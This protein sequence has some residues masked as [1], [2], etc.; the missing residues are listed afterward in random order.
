MWLFFPYHII[1]SKELV[2]INIEIRKPNKLKDFSHKVY[3]KLEDILFSIIQRLPERFIPPLLMAWLERYTDRRIAELNQQI[4][5]QR[6]HSAELQK[7]VN[8][9]HDRQQDL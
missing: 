3:N 8:V 2:D 4:T 7:T 6:W 5:R 9:I 1:F